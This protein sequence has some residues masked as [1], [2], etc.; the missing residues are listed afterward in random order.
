MAERSGNLSGIIAGRYAIEREIG[1]GGMAVVYLARD[2]RHDA[3][4][5]VKVLSPELAERV[6]PE[7]FSREIRI[8]AS[9]QHPNILSVFD[10]GEANGLPFCVMPYVEGE[11]LDAR[12]RREG[13][14]PIE[15]ALLIASEIADGLAYAHAQGFVHRDVKPSNILL[16]HGHARL[17]DFGI[18]RAIDAAGHDRLTTAGLA[19]G[20]ASYMSPEQASGQSVDG[21]SDI[22]SLGCVLYEMLAGAPPFTGASPRAILARHLTDPLPSVR[23][24]RTTVPPALETAL[25][26]AMAKLPADRFTDATEFRKAIRQVDTASVQSVPSTRFAGVWLAAAAVVIAGLAI[27]LGRRALDRAD[28]LDPNRIMVF[29]LVVSEG[30]PGPPSVGEDVATMIGNTLDGTGPLR[31]IDGW[32]RL[33]PERRQD[34]RGLSDAEARA[35]ARTQRCGFYV[36]GRVIR[37]NADSAQISLTLYSVR[38]GSESERSSAAAPIDEAWKGVRAVNSLLPRLIPGATRDVMAEWENRPP[39]AIANFL[40]GEAAFRRI[41]PDEA[42]ERYRTAVAADSTFAFAALRGAQAAS[43]SHR[44]SEAAALIET[45]ARQPLPPRY[46]AFARGYRAYLE[47]RADSAIAS[48]RSALAIDPE[49]AVAWLQLGETWTHLLPEAGTP[50]DSAL[51]AFREAVRLDPAAINP[52]FHIIEILVRR[53]ESEAAA[54]LLDRLLEAGP[55]RSYADQVRIMHDCV[56]RGSTAMPWDSL[57][58]SRPFELLMASFQLSGAGSQLPCAEAGF[59]ALLRN[60]TAAVEP[61][62]GDR[63]FFEILGLQNI[64]LARGRDADALA[65]VDAHVARWGSGSSLYLLSAPFSVAFAG[66]AAETARADSAR[67]G[68]AYA[69]LAFGNRL[70][71][72]G[73]FE[74][75]RGNLEAAAG[76]AA[77][78]EARAHRAELQ[79]GRLLA[80]SLR[81]HIALAH[82]DTGRALQLFDALVP[83]LAPGDLLRYDEAEPFG[84]ERLELARLLVA[85]GEYRRAIDIANVFDSAWPVV[86]TLYL[87]PSL[88][89]RMDAAAALGDSRLEAQFRV[90]LEALEG[91]PVT[92]P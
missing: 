59:S 82:A 12:I 8:T 77:E 19:V 56:R 36:T 35:L 90:R 34:I 9:L 57:A 39:L 37:L 81:A 26:K 72:L 22:Y 88:R 52:L 63:R 40:L 55:E 78:L 79:R 91:R 5:A 27:T 23:T 71:E 17:A 87:R 38:D 85:R 80:T 47:G 53:G 69:G 28:K 31:W 33:E 7:R 61:G 74:A 75:K 50:D 41:Q 6:G 89:L 32:A 86:H 46:A 15:E 65:R 14:L 84:A 11:T 73:L 30:F 67:H 24:V 60:D 16:S 45:A 42:L 21:R 49:M 70:W 44:N 3:P 4:V 83:A 64:Q 54:P 43:W 76:V 48:F 66:R 18:A 58:A 2:L 62:A 1:R 13:P 68:P 29:P 20:T 92:E 51:V 10:S 25:V